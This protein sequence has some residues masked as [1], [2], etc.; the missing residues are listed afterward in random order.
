MTSRTQLMDELSSSVP[1][2][3]GLGVRSLALFGSFARE[4][5]QQDSD[6]DL[7]AEIEAL[8]FDRYMDAKFLLEDRLHRKVDLVLAHTLKPALRERIL[9]ELV[10]VPGF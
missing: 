1:S 2:L 6:V 4:E 5:Q 7:L 9:S 8:S 3:R 10:R